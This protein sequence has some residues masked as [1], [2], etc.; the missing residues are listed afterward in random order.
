MTS[1]TCVTEL[2]AGA[3]HAAVSQ[4]VQQLQRQFV[5]AEQ[6][7]MMGGSSNHGSATPTKLRGMAPFAEQWNRQLLTKLQATPGV[8]GL[9]VMPITANSK[10]L[11]LCL[12]QE[13]AYAAAAWPLTAAP[14]TS[15]SNQA[16]SKR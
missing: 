4:Q 13:G 3:V 15:T 12:A 1:A 9:H 11:A 2:T 6:Q 16:Q 7:V 10:R 5:A 14:S 8:G